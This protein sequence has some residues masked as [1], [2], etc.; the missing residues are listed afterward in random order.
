MRNSDLLIKVSGEVLSKHP[1][2]ENLCRR[3]HELQTHEADKN[4][5]SNRLGKPL[6]KLHASTP[7]YSA[8]SLYKK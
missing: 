8:T 5:T 7:F 1:R 2:D 6:N 3:E 4:S